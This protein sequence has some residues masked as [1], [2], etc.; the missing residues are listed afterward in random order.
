MATLTELNF[1][2][3]KS[4][5]AI[6][7]NQATLTPAGL[8]HDLIYDRE[9]MVVDLQGNFMTQREHPAMARITPSIYADRLKLRAPGM[10]E[11]EI[12]LDLPDP[13]H[14]PTLTVRVWGD[15]LT[16][17]D[18]DAVTAQWFSRA[19]NIP[20]RLVRFHPH[21][22]RITN[23]R[24]TAHTDVPALFSDGYPFLLISQASL[25]DL[26][27]KLTAQGRA[28]LPMNRFRP[29]IVIDGVGA[30][31]EDYMESL[32]IGGATLKP[33]KPC[34]RCSIPAVDQVNG[35]VGPD[36]LD[37]LRSYRSNPKVDGGIAFGMNTMLLTGEA[38]VVRVGQEV[39]ITLA[40]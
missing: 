12:P 13:E 21:A 19:L 2:P 32:Y 7:L 28:P 9:W 18:C 33:V 26:N 3:I 29:N 27:L 11:L 17:Y 38:Q 31:E 23:T 35:E 24:W 15:T 30:F 4:C 25:A 36:P 16:A 20:C 14:A 1:Y 39:A 6:A 34:V 5:G 37:I 8:M 40:F 10:L 22:S